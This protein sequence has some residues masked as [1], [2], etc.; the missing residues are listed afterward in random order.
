MAE[1]DVVAGREH[2][3]DAS[4]VERPLERAGEQELAGAVEA[5]VDDA[6]AEVAE[7]GEGDRGPRHPVAG[8]VRKRLS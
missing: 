4:R 7:H 5:P 3:P 8:N 1:I 2:E 6:D